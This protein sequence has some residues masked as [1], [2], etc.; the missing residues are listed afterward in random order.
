[1]EGEV[2]GLLK[3]Y[4][5]VCALGDRKTM[6]SIIQEK[7]QKESYYFLYDFD[8][9]VLAFILFAL[10]SAQNFMSNCIH[11]YSYNFSSF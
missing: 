10:V 5:I 2:P 3:G 11:H 9:V 8:Y 7:R 4:D 1:V 6:K